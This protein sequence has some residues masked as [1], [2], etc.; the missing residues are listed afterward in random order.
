MK[1]SNVRTHHFPQSGVTVV[2][3][4]S[5]DGSDPRV[6]V[7]MVATDKDTG[8]LTEQYNR[9]L[10]KL[11]A[12]GRA[13]CNAHE[14]NLAGRVPEKHLRGCISDTRRW[15][16]GPAIVKRDKLS[17]IADGMRERVRH[18]WASLFVKDV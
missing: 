8:K 15:E 11:I 3:L 9:A 18:A 4:L 12:K 6:G 16:P 5:N 17:P 1:E 13:E 10:G 2:V 7:A 14:V